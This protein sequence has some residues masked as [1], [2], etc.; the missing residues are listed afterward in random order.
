MILRPPIAWPPLDGSLSSD[1]REWIVV[2]GDIHLRPGQDD[3]FM[4][5]LREL[6]ANPP[7]HLIILGD[8]FDYWLDCPEFIGFY[9]SL[10]DVL[11]VLSSA[12]IALHCVLG[13]REMAAGC[14]FQAA[15]P[16]RV[17]L[18][19]LDIK[20]PAM[21]CCVSFMVTASYG[22]RLPLNGCLAEFLVVPNV[23]ILCPLGFS[24][25][26]CALVAW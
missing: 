16:G 14:H 25:A 7:E 5:F 10:F 2:C 22:S 23:S 19:R 21:G 15:F 4:E 12:W 6:S 26:S 9:Q 13:N 8:L 3:A 17:Y 24:A 11:G 20:S 1:H 18:R